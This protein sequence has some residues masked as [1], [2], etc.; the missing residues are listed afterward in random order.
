MAAPS[1]GKSGESDLSDIVSRALGTVKNE[2]GISHKMSKSTV[3][4]SKK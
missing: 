4:G 3:G 2:D 1:H